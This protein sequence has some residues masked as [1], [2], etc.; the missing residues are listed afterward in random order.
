MIS[1]KPKSLT[2]EFATADDEKVYDNILGNEWSGRFLAEAAGYN[3]DV[4][5]WIPVDPAEWMIGEKY[6]NLEGVVRKVVYDDVVEFFRSTDGNP[7]HRFYDMAA[8][9]EGIGSG[10]SFKTAIMATYFLHLLLCLREPQRYFGGAKSS[11]LAIMNM[12]ISEKNAKK[13]IFSEI[14]SKIYD[15]QWFRDRPWHMSD[16]RMPDPDCLSELRFKN[17]IFII[18]GSSSWRTAVGYNIIVGIMDEAGAYRATDRSDQA[19]DIFNALQRR[20]GS[21]FESKGA[22]II[23]GSPLYE[24]D[25]LEKKLHEA[26][27]PKSRIYAKRRTLWEAKYGDWDGE[28]FYVD[29]INRVILDKKPENMKN[30]DAIPHIPFLFTAFRANVTKAYRDFGARPS[31]T[32]NPF[33]EAPKV[34]LERYNRDR[35]NDPIAKNGTI[36]SWL[37]CQDKNAFH[38]VHIDLALT[39]AACGFALGHNAGPTEEGGTKIYIDLMMRL[40]GSKEAPIRISK[41]REYIYALTALGFPISLVTYDGFQS[42]DSMQIL[43]GK[44]YRAEYLSVDRTMTPYSNLKEAINEKRLDYYYIPSGIEDE[45]SSSEVFVKECMQLEEIKGKKIDHPPK[46]SKDVSDAVAGVVHN[47]LEN[48]DYYGIVTVGRA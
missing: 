18:P 13:V 35:T 31:P 16:A 46:G 33:F 21:R 19:E 29:R 11:K 32:L 9:C 25:F 4:W 17:N 8:L 14:T 38:A 3:S 24:S 34:V 23:A 26:E 45:P 36:E 12:S 40:Q 22:I 20:L 42:S 39:G 37:T 15:S 28:F 44:G 7:W 5:R 48:S 10:K 43:E 41:V 1:K 27:K 30:V 6:L 2:S 47:I